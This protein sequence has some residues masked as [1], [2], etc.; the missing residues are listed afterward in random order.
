MSAPAR[1]AGLVERHRRQQEKRRGALADAARDVLRA[2]QW[3][4]CLI[5]EQR[6]QQIRWYLGNGDTVPRDI[7]ELVLTDPH[8]IAAGDTLFPDLA[9]PQT[10]RWRP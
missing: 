6:L 7:V 8:V 10:Y 9:P 5:V 2:M 3:G 1:H 4:Q